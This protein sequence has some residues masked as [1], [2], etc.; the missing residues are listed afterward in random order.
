MIKARWAGEGFFGGARFGGKSDLLLGDYLQDVHEYG[1]AWRGVLF[2]K[3]FPQLED[4]IVRSKEIY[5][6]SYPGA[7]FKDQSKTWHFPNGA[8]LRMRSLERDAL[9]DNYI[10]H[11]YTWIG[12]DELPTWATPTPYIKLMACL[13]SGGVPVPVKR[14]RS[15]GN[16]GGIGHVWV[17]ERFVGVHNAYAW[18]RRVDPKTGITRVFIPSVVTDN[19]IGLRNDPGYVDRLYSLAGV[20]E[21]LVDSWLRG[22]WDVIAGAYF[23]HWGPHLIR[24][25]HSIRLEPHWPRWLG[26]DWGFKHNTAVYWF[27]T[28]DEGKTG[29]YDEHVISGQ[30]VGD[31]A[32]QIGGRSERQR[33]EDFWLSHDCF[34]ERTSDKTT[35]IQLGEALA[36]WGIPEPSRASTDRIGGSQLLYRM[37]KEN[38]LWVSSK[39]AELCNI[40]PALIHDPEKPEQILKMDGDDPFDGWRYGAYGKLGPRQI[41][42][43]DRVMSKVTST[44]PTIRAMQIQMAQQ[45]LK[46]VGVEPGADPNAGVPIGTPIQYGS[47]FS[48]P[49]PG[50]RR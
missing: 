18:Q 12:W 46:H 14:V 7:V 11:A 32:E 19:K 17:K 31:L 29:C 24:D 39:C 9:A 35:A 50:G 40:I 23:D 8:Y 38:K 42:V 41:P 27:T 2:R 10:G 1:S 25:E 6:R 5:L 3:T 4:L 28:D 43:E 48:G 26:M 20:S 21:A 49:R 34:A 36:P 30:S 44:D 45:R 47:K 33:I 15:T 16:P 22:D 13:R 37:M